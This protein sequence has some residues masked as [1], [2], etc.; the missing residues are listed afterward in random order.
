MVKSFKSV[1]FIIVRMYEGCPESFKT[2]S[3]SQNDFKFK[4][5]SLI[6]FLANVR[7]QIGSGF[8]LSTFFLRSY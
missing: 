8:T 3:V 5:D 6:Q 1:I 4:T 2:V 7:E